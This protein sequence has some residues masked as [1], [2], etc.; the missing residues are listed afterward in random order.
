MGFTGVCS[1]TGDGQV[2]QVLSLVLSGDEGYTMDM[3]RIVPLLPPSVY[4]TGSTPLARISFQ[5]NISHGQS[6]KV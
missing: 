1:F 3:T 6:T 5:E 4:A 2:P